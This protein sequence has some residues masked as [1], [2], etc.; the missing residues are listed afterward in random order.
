MSVTVPGEPNDVLEA[1]HQGSIPRTELMLALVG[2]IVGDQ[3]SNATI[4]LNFKQLLLQP[5]EHVPWILTLAP[6]VP[7]ERIASLGVVSD[8]A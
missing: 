7:V 6:S 2:S 1:F 5:G 4:S 8:D 3:E